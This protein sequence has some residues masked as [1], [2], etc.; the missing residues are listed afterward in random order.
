MWQFIFYEIDQVLRKL[1]CG[2]SNYVSAEHMQF[3][4]YLEI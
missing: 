3:Q 4:T 1:S 2:I